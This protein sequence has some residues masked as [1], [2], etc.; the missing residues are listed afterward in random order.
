MT[1]GTLIKKIQIA[2]HREDCKLEPRRITGW[3]RSS[4]GHGILF[5]YEIP[6][7]KRFDPA[8]KERLIGL[9]REALAMASHRTQAEWMLNSVFSVRGMLRITHSETSPH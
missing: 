5:T 1:N 8:D 6:K 3:M 7:G 9:F 4:L 2:P